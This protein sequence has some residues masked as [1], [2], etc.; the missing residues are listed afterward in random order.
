[1]K[2]CF[3]RL[4]IVMYIVIAGLGFTT[5]LASAQQPT[6]YTVA[7]G[8]VFKNGQEI[9][10]HGINWF[11][12]EARHHLRPYGLDVRDYKDSI[13]QMK[14]LG[15]TAIRY[16]VCPK[17][18]D[19][20]P[21]ST[22]TFENGKNAELQG[23]NSL[24]VMDTIIQEFNNQEMYILL[25]MHSIDCDNLNQLWYSNEYSPQEWQ[26]DLEFMADRYKGLEY[27]MGIDLKNEPFGVATWG[28]GT[29]NDWKIAAETA[30]AAVLQQNPSLLVFVEGVQENPLCSNGVNH[31]Q[32][33]NLEPQQCYPIDTTKIPADKLVF[34]PHVYGPDVYTQP[35][36]NDP[37]FPNNLFNIWET[38]FGFMTNTGATLVIGEWGGK[39]GN[40]GGNP[41]DTQLQTKL[42]EYY[43]EKNLC[44]T[45]YWA[46]NA[47]A[48]DTGGILQQDWQTPWQ[49]KLDALN[50][51]QANCTTGI[52][53][54]VSQVVVKAAGTPAAAT[55][56]TLQLQVNGVTMKT[57]FNVQGNAQAGEFNEFTYNSPTSLLG[58]EVKVVYINDGVDPQGNDRNVRVDSISIDGNI[59]QAEAPTVVTEGS[60]NATTG[61]DLRVATS[62]WLHCNGYFKFAIPESQPTPAPS[63]SPLPSPSV[64]PSPSPNP[65][66][67]PSPSPSPTPSTQIQIFAAGTPVSGVY[68]QLQLSVRDEVVKTFTNVRGNTQTRQFMTLSH[69]LPEIV[70][71]KDIKVAFINDTS[72]GNE[73]RNILID[74]LVVNGQVF[75]TEAETTYAEGSWNATD[76]CSGRNAQSEWL[77]CNGYFTYDQEPLTQLTVWAAGTPVNNVYPVLKVKIRGVE[78]GQM[79]NIRGIPE[80]RVFVPY[81]M[82]LTEPVLPGDIELQFINDT[83][84]N[85]EDRNVRVDK[86]KINNLEYQAESISTYS[87][88]SWSAPTGCSPRYAQSEWLHCNGYFR[89]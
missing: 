15:F 70:N 72:A 81:T 68:P 89:F 85:T 11:G 43:Q 62:E 19:N 74:K 58:E 25:D 29:A 56:P 47:N 9:R 32:G 23:K 78:V 55:Y 24:D 71:A 39:F 33:G 52:P 54:T 82:T 34:S 46:W 36:I 7:G 37:T 77:H 31:W 53:E 2:N 60:W 8:K 1:M 16:P 21:V 63:A 80:T 73:D 49:N 28:T 75:E 65:S 5:E 12:S 17:T 76:G 51:F 84:T 83:A 88:G 35:Y 20:F 13:S 3:A 50:A 64:L 4:C 14:S 66:P 79:N 69:T 48:L 40:E 42:I 27:F 22:I 44:N 6:Q 41:L 26:S 57:F 67:M 86:I 45:F 30:G 59:Y 10:L 18:L 87:Q 61:C 38:H